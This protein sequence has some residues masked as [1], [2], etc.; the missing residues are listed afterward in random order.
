MFAW[1]NR[2]R[3]NTEPT[4]QVEQI[5][6]LNC[7]SGSLLI[8]EPMGI[9]GDPHFLPDIPIGDHP[10]FVQMIRYPEGGRRVAKLGIRFREGQPIERKQLD[11]L[12]IDSAKC[13][14]LD[15]G[16]FKKYWDF[17]GPVRFGRT[18]ILDGK[19]HVAELLADQFDL[20]WRAAPDGYSLECTEPISVELEEQINA[21]LKTVPGFSPYPF[22][23]F[24]VVTMTTSD[25]VAEAMLIEDGPWVEL[26]LDEAGTARLYAIKTGFGDGLYNVEGLFDN[27]GII[28]IEIEFIGPEQEKLLEAFPVL[29]Y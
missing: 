15:Y 28:A 11:E 20:T 19:S 25:R 5:G 21:Y 4:V 2:F 6:S 10:V 12:G 14:F 3:K 13:V 22:F 23:Y 16:D 7:H 18:T 9:S 8:R 17:E 29:R 26:R 1:L 24:R 27:E